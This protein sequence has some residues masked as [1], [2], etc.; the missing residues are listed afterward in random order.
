M[1]EEVGRMYLQGVSLWSIALKFGVTV[2]AVEHHLNTK[3]KPAWRERVGNEAFIE[4]AKVNL[5][6]RIAYEQFARSKRKLTKETI[7]QE[8]NAKALEDP[9]KATDPKIVER[10]L[11]TIKRDGDATWLHIVQWCIDWRSKVG[12][13]YAP[14]RHVISGETE[15]RVAGLSRDDLDHQMLNRLAELIAARTSKQPQ[16]GKSNGK[17]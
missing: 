15:L 10:A 9:E 13:H 11:Q 7:K 1:I 17:K 14:E 12:G 2:H 3:I 6:E 8:L 5:L 4:M 16:G